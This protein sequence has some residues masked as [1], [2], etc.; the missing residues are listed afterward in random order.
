MPSYV[1]ELVV[2][3][4]DLQSRGW[5]ALCKPAKLGEQKTPAEALLEKL[6][7]RGR[8]PASVWQAEY[9]GRSYLICRYP[10]NERFE[11]SRLL[12]DAV[13]SAQKGMGMV[14][15]HALPCMV[16]EI[17][18]GKAGP[19]YQ[20][21]HSGFAHY[22]VEPGKGGKFLSESVSPGSPE[23]L[24]ETNIHA[25]FPVLP[26][27]GPKAEAVASSGPPLGGV[28]PGVNERSHRPGPTSPGPAA[29]TLIGSAATGA[30]PRSVMPS[31]GGW[32]VPASAPGV[33]LSSARGSV[34]RALDRVTSAAA[35][36]LGAVHGH[37]GGPSARPGAGGVAPE[38]AGAVAT[39]G[40]TP[41]Q[42]S[43]RR[44]SGPTAR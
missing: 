16:R 21:T 23:V 2:S 3:L 15:S 17:T 14:S 20:H 26:P 24:R 32:A 18:D 41:K 12:T 29:G 40:A 31:A 39:K 8:Q 30:P 37:K 7:I 36:V 11:G 25:D 9:D 27:P 1:A 22:P 43:S 13:I 4:D 38:V 19:P 42:P 10:S 28:R 6:R 34:S 33:P 5:G 35:S 44:P